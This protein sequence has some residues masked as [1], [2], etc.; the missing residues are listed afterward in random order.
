VLVDD[1]A[2][3]GLLSAD[4][5]SLTFVPE[6]PVFGRLMAGAGLLGFR[7]NGRRRRRA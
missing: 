1:F 7:R 4:E 3:E 5:S 2:I 6:P